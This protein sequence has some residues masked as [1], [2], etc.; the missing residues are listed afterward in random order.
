MPR[1]LPCYPDER[2]GLNKAHKSARNYRMINPNNALEYR[3]HIPWDVY[4]NVNLLYC[5]RSDVFP[6][7]PAIIYSQ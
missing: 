6:L 7:R 1:C 5:N 3:V 4:K 2:V